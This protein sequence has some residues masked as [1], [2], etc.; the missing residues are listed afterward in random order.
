M[1]PI[2]CYPWTR[3][4]EARPN[5]GVGITWWL[6]NIHHVNVAS[7]ELVSSGGYCCYVGKDF[8]RTCPTL[9]EAK[10]TIEAELNVKF[11]NDK[12]KTML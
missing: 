1:K 11:I 6:Y 12:L 2:L 8:L 3:A 9:R 4:V 5:E 7:I 10:Q